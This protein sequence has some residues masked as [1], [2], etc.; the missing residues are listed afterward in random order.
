MGK[1]VKKVNNLSKVI[2]RSFIG[3]LVLLLGAYYLY[4]MIS[5]SLGKRG[6][7]E[8]KRVS[9]GVKRSP[10][11]DRP[12]RQSADL[13][14]DRSSDVAVRGLKSRAQKIW[15]VLDRERPTSVSD[16]RRHFPEV[17]VRTLRRDMNDMVSKGYVARKGS[18][19]STVYFKRQG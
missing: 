18:T 19:K 15:K 1:M 8:K 5:D 4:L 11:S 16:I 2:V 10:R 17:T 13:A 7:S 6:K 14:R 12:V 9:L 3:V